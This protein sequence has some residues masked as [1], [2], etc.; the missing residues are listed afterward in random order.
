[1]VKNDRKSRTYNQKSTQYIH[2]LIFFSH[3]NLNSIDPDQL[4]FIWEFI[5]D[6][7]QG[8]QINYINNKISAYK[9]WATVYCLEDGTN[10][11]IISGHNN[12]FFQWGYVF[13]Q[14]PK[15]L[16][17]LR[18]NITKLGKWTPYKRDP[19]EWFT[20]T[21]EVFKGKKYIVNPFGNEEMH[22][23]NF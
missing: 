6:N 3:L 10:H 20:T 1:L 2:F 7:P 12:F 21:K 11:L 4:F 19:I 9:L 14:H 17:W 22:L 18:Q 13:F 15:I 5:F 23:I 8:T 16:N